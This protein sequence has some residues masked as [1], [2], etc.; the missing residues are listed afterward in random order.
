MA[1]DLPTILRE[2][3]HK[4]VVQTTQGIVF[5]RTYL[6]PVYLW[7]LEDIIPDKDIRE[8][9]EQQAGV[10]QYDLESTIRSRCSH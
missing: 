4:Q 2:L 9:V 3:V 5:Q 1:T 6:E 7:Y 8:T 10:K